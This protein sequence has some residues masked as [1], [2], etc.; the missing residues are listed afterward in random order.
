MPDDN[1]QLYLSDLVKLLR[2]DLEEARKARDT[3]PRGSDRKPFEEGRAFAYCEVL[4]TMV[5]QAIAFGIDQRDI[6]LDRFDPDREMA[7]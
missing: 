2:T 7:K 5:H 6:G 4:S 3:P 1:Y